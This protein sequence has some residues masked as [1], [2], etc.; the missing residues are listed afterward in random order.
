[1]KCPY[2]GCQAAISPQAVQSLCKD[3]FDKYSYFLVRDMEGMKFCP[4]PGCEN[5]VMIVVGIE[6]FNCGMC[7][8]AYCPGCNKENGHPKM[9]C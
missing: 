4:T 2:Q 1:M 6:I 3:H 8:K 5:G 7:G 9:T